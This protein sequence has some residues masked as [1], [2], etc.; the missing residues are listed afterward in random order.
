MTTTVTHATGE[1]IEISGASA[2]TSLDYQCTGGGGGKPGSGPAS[3]AANTPYYDGQQWV[4]EFEINADRMGNKDEF[5][6]DLSDAQANAGVDYSD[7]TATVA[8]G[9]GY[10]DFEFDKGSWTISYSAQG[11]TD[12]PFVIRLTGVQITSDQDGTAYFSDWNGEEDSDTFDVPAIGND[13]TT[14]TDG[15][16]VVEDGTSADDEIDA[17]GSVTIGDGA[18]ANDDVD[19]G[20]DVTVGDSGTIHGDL[21]SGGDVSLGDGATANNEVEADGDV[22]VGA[23]GTIHGELSAGGDVTIGP[24]GTASDDVTAGGDVTVGMAVPSTAT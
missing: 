13:G 19:A 15:D 6:I 20:S 12:G 7:A 14:E 1:R 3:F 9:Q 4:Q 10:R 17:G 24:D 18:T 2:S 23:D 8:S 5:T 11:A 21:D 22:A 16:L